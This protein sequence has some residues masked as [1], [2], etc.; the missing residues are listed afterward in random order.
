MTTSKKQ[1]SLPDSLNNPNL[2]I[3]YFATSMDDTPPDGELLKFY[4]TFRKLN[5]NI[6]FQFSR[7]RGRMLSGL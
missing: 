4:Y 3:D 7:V 1:T 5:A 6:S 2:I